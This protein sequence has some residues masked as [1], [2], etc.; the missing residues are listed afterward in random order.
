[1]S[2]LDFN[3]LFGD[4]TVDYACPKCKANIP[5]ALNDVNKS[6]ICPSCGVKIE[7]QKDENFDN[8]VDK[9]NDSLKDLKNTLDSFGK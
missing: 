3:S 8:S 2:D 1:M 5:V 6:V 7:F 4:S 9:V